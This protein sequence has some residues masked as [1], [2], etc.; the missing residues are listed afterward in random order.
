ML[1]CPLPISDVKL[2]LTPHPKRYLKYVKP[3]EFLVIKDHLRGLQIPVNFKIPVGNLKADESWQP[4]PDDSLPV[5]PAGISID[6][7]INP[8]GLDDIHTESVVFIPTNEVPF[9][10]A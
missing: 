2:H 10:P 4:V 1:G 5:R 6:F 8:G 7:E 3:E 9:S